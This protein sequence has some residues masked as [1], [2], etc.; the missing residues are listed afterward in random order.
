MGKS[1][2][3]KKNKMKLPKKTAAQKKQEKRAKKSK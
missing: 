2:D 3:A 1:L